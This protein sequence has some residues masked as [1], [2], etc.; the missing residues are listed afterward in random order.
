M[1]EWTTTAYAVVAVAALVGG[2]A[3]GGFTGVISAS[4]DQQANYDP[5]TAD[6]SFVA[7]CGDDVGET[8]VTQVFTEVD[9]ESKLWHVDFT[10]TGT[11]DYVLLKFGATTLEITEGL[12][13]GR[14]SVFDDGTEV[15]ANNC[16]AGDD[17]IKYERQGD[18]PD[19]E[20]VAESG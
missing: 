11:V 19:S 12:D 18:P 9:G 8:T 3:A 14:V 15:S 17:G 6:V 10:A 7:L 5:N 13:D 2:A 4:H 20:L 16:D 1:P